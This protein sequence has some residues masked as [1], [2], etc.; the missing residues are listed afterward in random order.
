MSHRRLSPY[1]LTEAQ[2]L[3]GFDSVVLDATQSREAKVPMPVVP[4]AR[5]CAPTEGSPGKE[6]ARE[7]QRASTRLPSSSGTFLSAMP[8]ETREIAHATLA[9][10]LKEEMSQMH[11]A[12]MHML[13]F[14]QGE[15]QL[16]HLD[17]D[18]IEACYEDDASEQY[19]VFMLQEAGVSASP[20]V[21]V[22]FRDVGF[23]M[24][25]SLWDRPEPF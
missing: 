5:T 10:G 13:E 22:R 14:L 8:A 20:S 19:R 1:Q 9:Q 6:R 23:R 4:P 7:A 21:P 18:A 24:L 15:A 2:R 3:R 17:G 16:A 12:S 25:C 11:K